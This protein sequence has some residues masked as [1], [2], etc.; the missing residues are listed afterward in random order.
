MKA[1]FILGTILIVLFSFALSLYLNN[2]KWPV[3]N[4]YLRG[5]LTL[6]L[7][8]VIFIFPFALVVFIIWPPLL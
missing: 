1:F 8:F 2:Y 6:V 7:S 5:L 4:L 3:H